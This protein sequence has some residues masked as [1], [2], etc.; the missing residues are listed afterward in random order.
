MRA[1]LLPNP[2]RKVNDPAIDFLSLYVMFQGARAG[3]IHA[4]A[5]AA[6]CYNLVKL[7]VTLHPMRFPACVVLRPLRARERRPRR[8]RSRDV[9]GE[10]RL[11]TRMRRCLEARGELD[12]RRLAERGAEEADAH[13]EAE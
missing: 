2:R 4:P 12:Q 7:L 9:S 13:R 10:G 5:L 11:E 1:P 8:I 3:R 6:F